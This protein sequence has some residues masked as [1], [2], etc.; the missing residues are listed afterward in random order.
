MAD[1][2]SRLE[3]TLRTGNG[4]Y[5]EAISVSQ[6]AIN[7]NLEILLALYPELG[8]IG[9]K[10]HDGDMSAKVDSP[11]VALQV[12]GSN[13]GTV[14]YYCRFK[15]GTVEPWDDEL[16]SNAPPIDVTGWVLAFSVDIAAVN[17]PEDSDDYQNATSVINQPGDYSISR[18]YL[19]FNIH[20]VKVGD[21][22][23]G[24]M[25]EPKKTTIGYT[26]KA[27]NPGTVNPHAPTFPPTSFIFQTYEYIAP[28][29]TEPHQGLDE[30][31]DKNH[32]LYLEMT[33]HLDFPI[34]RFLPYSGNFVT[35][36]MDGTICISKDIFF[37]SYLLRKKEPLLLNVFNKY[38]YAWIAD[39]KAYDD[40]PVRFT[41]DLRVGLGSSHDQDIDFFGFEEVNTADTPKWEWKRS[42]STFDNPK[43]VNLNCDAS[44][45]TT[46]FPKP[47]T[48]EL[49]LTGESQIKFKFNSWP[50]YLFGGAQGTE[51]S[52]TATWSLTI[53]LNS[54]MEGGLEI[55]LNVPENQQHLFKIST[56][57]D[58]WPDLASYPPYEE[59]LKQRMADAITGVPLRDIANDLQKALSNSAKF[60]IPG[61]GTFFYKD[62][63]FNNHGDVLIEAE[64]NGQVT[65]TP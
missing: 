59:H 43:A 54:V 55:S 64:Y 16:N 21:G 33:Q 17:V 3:A 24:V 6:K 61:G 53:T 44:N 40:D 26:M 7:R 39:H 8:E 19:D 38:T 63:I 50:I 56:Y 2:P 37:G 5:S 30:E 28:R 18:L 10:T 42:E 13:R 31:G 20:H 25:S 22:V 47:G 1:D 51:A 46:L 9:L 23:N 15:E 62:P 52:A 11:Q 29:T 41:A 60:V 27:N 57:F 12:A 58:D 36:P 32:L 14:Y 49:L 34:Q 45:K 4:A 65:Q 48:N 35:P